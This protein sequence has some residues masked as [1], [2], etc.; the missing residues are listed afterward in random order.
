MVEMAV[1]SPAATRS[2]RTAEP[3]VKGG[4]GL[5]L[6]IASSLILDDVSRSTVPSR[7]LVDRSHSDASLFADSRA[8]VEPAT[9]LARL[10]DSTA[11]SRGLSH[12][13]AR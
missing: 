4:S 8:G 11:P 3:R 12:N 7:T 5:R 6:I 10:A 1:S 13:A 9:T 2:E